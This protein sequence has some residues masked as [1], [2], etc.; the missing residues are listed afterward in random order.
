MDV[1]E[2]IRKRASANKFDPARPLSEA[3]VR[4]LVELATRAPSSF[5]IQHWRFLA[6]TRKEDREKLKGLAYNQQKVADAPVVFVVLG[7]PRAHENLAHALEGSVKAGLMD[8][9]AVQGLS[10][11]AAGMYADPRAQRDEAIRSGAFAAMTLMLAAEA[12]GLVAGPMIGF[13]PD[14]VKKEFK[15]PERL[16]PVLMLPVGYAAPGNWPQKPRLPVDEVLA[17]HDGAK[18]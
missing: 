6:V 17:F 10:G 7:D 5:N 1:L 2:A 11:M 3:Q 8:A 9:K 15:I 13:D 18:L 16:I 12:K 4:E 14:A